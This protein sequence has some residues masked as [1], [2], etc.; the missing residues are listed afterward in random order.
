MHGTLSSNQDFI[1]TSMTEK[2]AEK[3]RNMEHQQYNNQDI[4]IYF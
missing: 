1:M 4:G 3:K 2:C